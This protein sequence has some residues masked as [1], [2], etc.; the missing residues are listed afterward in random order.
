M[1]IAICYWGMTRSVKQ[2]YKSHHAHLFNILKNHGIDYD[3]YIHTWQTGQNMVWGEDCKVPIDYDEYKLLSP[4]HYSI[5]NQDEFLNSLDFSNY[6]N[7]ELYN[8]HGGDTLHEWRPYLI[9]NHLCALESQRRVY[10]MVCEQHIQYDFILFIRPDVIISTDFDYNILTTDFDII[11]PNYDHF[12]GL[13]DKFAILQ[14]NCASHYAT[15]INEIIEFRQNNG[16]IVSEKYVKFI[17]EKYYHNV[18]FI[19]FIMTLTRPV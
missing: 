8:I 13:N 5:D 19:D 10:N 17:V 6:F 15:R 4:T 3:V 16:R 14:F 18:K 11:L 2:T 1:K 12:N 9:R 7:A